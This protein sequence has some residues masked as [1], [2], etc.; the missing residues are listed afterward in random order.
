MVV[1]HWRAVYGWGGFTG[2]VPAVPLEIRA[3][4]QNQSRRTGTSCNRKYS[5]EA[6]D[7]VLPV[8]ED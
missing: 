6:A 2:R 8:V 7:G 3:K 4:I 1:V 5:F